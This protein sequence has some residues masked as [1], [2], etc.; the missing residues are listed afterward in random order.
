MLMFSLNKL[1]NTQLEWHELNQS[2]LYSL[3]FTT[4]M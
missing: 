4:E 3:A 2:V 1:K